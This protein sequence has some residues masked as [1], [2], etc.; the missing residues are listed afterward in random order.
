MPDVSVN[1]T[2]NVLNAALKLSPSDRATV[3]LGLLE[4]LDEEESDAIEEEL[5][6]IWAAEVKRRLDEL[7][8]GTAREIDAFDAIA[9]LRTELHK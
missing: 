9:R 2:D 3:V 8:S 5:D 4:S 6:E 7:D 1:A